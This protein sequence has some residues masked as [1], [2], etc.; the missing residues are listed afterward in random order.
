MKD[1]SNDNEML[2]MAEVDLKEIKLKKKKWK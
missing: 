1:K 2:A